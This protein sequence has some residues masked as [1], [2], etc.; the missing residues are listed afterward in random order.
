[1][2]LVVDMLLWFSAIACGLLAG[3]YFTFSAF[4]MTALGSIGRAAG[5]AAMN[6]INRVILRSAFMPLFFG[7]SLSSLAL[8]AIGAVHWGEPGAAAMALG[9]AVYV[10]GMPVV[11]MARNVPLNNALLAADPGGEAGAGLW[12]VYD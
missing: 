5:V 3:V 10:L 12:A 8:A 1:M 7:S 9:G 2:H 6:A 11:T 4:V